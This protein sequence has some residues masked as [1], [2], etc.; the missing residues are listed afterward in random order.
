[1]APEEV[2]RRLA[3]QLPEGLEIRAVEATGPH[4]RRQPRELSYRVPLLSGH[5]V[6]R[7]RIAE[8]MARERVEVERPRKDTVKQVEIRQFIGALRLKEGALLMLLRYTEAG[9]ARPEEVLEAL[10]CREGVHY[11]YG[12]IERVH[13]SLPPAR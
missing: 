3:G 10:G 7:E 5:P 12:Q 8:L 1:M 6:D 13:V 2:R 4:P 9:T 11:R